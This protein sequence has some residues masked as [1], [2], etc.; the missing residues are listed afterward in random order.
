MSRLAE[1]RS[2]RSEIL[3]LAEKHGARN[4]RLFGSTARGD[5]RP[6][7]DVDFLIDYGERVSFFFPGGFLS[8]LE[9][10]LH[11][12]VDI[13]TERSLRPPLKQAILRDAIAI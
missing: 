7:S 12:K 8:D 2:K 11:C 10:M 6:D 13:V 4:V 3:A 1:I 5:D 9:A